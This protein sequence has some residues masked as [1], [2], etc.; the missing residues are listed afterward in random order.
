MMSKK[1]ILAFFVIFLL[2]GFIQ[3]YTVT[4]QSPAVRLV[5]VDETGR[6]LTKVSKNVEVQVQIEAL[7]PTPEVYRTIFY[8]SLRKPSLLKFWDSGNTVKIPLSDENLQ[9]VLEVWKKEYPEGTT[10]SLAISVWVLDYENGK[11]YRGFATIGCSSADLLKGFKRVVKIDIHRLPPSPLLPSEGTEVG[12]STTQG[13]TLTPLGSNRQFYYWKIDWNLSWRPLNYLEVPVLI[14]DNKGSYSGTVNAWIDTTSTYTTR[15]GVTIAYGFKI[16]GTETPTLDIYGNE[17]YTLQNK[18]EFAWG[19]LLRPNEKGYIYIKAKPIHLHEKEY[20]CTASLNNC[21]PTEKERIREGISD[22]ETSG[23]EIIGG[24]KYE[25]SDSSIM[26]WTYHGLD[27]RYATTLN[28]GDS[29]PLGILVSNTLGSCFTNFGIGVPIGALAVAMSGGTVPPWAAGL[30][31][32][33]DYASSSPFVVFG[34]L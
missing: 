10:S 3:I 17:F 27:M 4:S 29:E 31:I 30:S 2:I 20:Y 32:G 34:V 15:F 7:V 26:Y 22:V 12:N 21:V 23:K 28:P 1:I 9:Y 16:S 6:P 18:Y 19:L 5:L 13:S 33:I 8:G 14:V 24:S 11:V 25:L